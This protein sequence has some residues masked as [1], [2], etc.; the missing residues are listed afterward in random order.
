MSRLV[1]AMRRTLT[2]S[3]CVPPTRVKVPSF[4]KPQELGLKRLAHVR[5]F[6]EKNRAAIGFFNATGLLFH[7][8]G[9]RALFV[10]K[11]FA[12][13]QG[14][15]DGGAIDA[16]VTRLAALAQSVQGAG[17]QF[18]AGAAFAENEHPAHRFRPTVWISFR[19]SRILGDS[20]RSSRG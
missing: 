11:Q 6:I 15:G 4:E 17:D 20:P 1:A 7:R 13:E 9:E 19:N 8:A 16:D 5:D 14:F 18:L 2:R 12:F 3:S 10:A